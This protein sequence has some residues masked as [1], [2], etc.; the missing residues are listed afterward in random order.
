MPVP[1]SFKRTYKYLSFPYDK[2][3]L[4]TGSLD[5]K[6]I[7]TPKLIKDTIITTFKKGINYIWVIFLNNNKIQSY[8]GHFLISR[9]LVEDVL[10]G[11]RT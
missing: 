5:L 7:S 11:E 3:D 9:T 1:F 2:I 6:K 4:I 10:N 8:S